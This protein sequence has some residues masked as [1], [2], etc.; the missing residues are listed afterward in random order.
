MCICIYPRS[1]KKHLNGY[2]TPD[3]AKWVESCTIGPTSVN[4][5]VRIGDVL[6]S[7]YRVEGILGAGAMGIVVVARHEHLGSLVALKFMRPDAVE[8]REARDRFNREARAVARLRG[9]H[10]ARVLDFGALDTGAPYIVMEFLEGA[11]L[12]AVL[13]E[14][15]PLPIREAL[16]YVL[17]VCKAMEEAHRAGIVH[18][19]LKPKNLFLTHRPDGTPL[20]K[21]L[22]F[23]ISKVVD[24]NE[25][26]QAMSTR[27]S[28]FLGTPIFMSPEQIRSAKYVDA[29]TDIYALGAVIYHLVT[30]GFPFHA[31]SFGELF[32][33]IFHQEPTPLRAK[34]LDAPM[35][36]EAIVARCLQKEPS[37]RFQNVAELATELRKL[38]ESPE[39]AFGRVE[40]TSR[41]GAQTRNPDAR[42][43]VPSSETLTASHDPSKEPPALPNVPPA[44]EPP[45]AHDMQNTFGEVLV[46]SL[47]FGGSRSRPAYILRAGL[48]LVATFVLVVTGAFLSHMQRQSASEP[49]P[50]DETSAAKTSSP[51][52]TST[53]QSQQIV[54]LVAPVAPVAPVASMQTATPSTDAGVATDQTSR[55]TV[56]PRVEGVSKN[57]TKS[58]AALPSSLHYERLY[59]HEQGSSPRQ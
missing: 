39:S 41:D 10:I 15:G 38:L 23:G 35:A 5:P 47:A 53:R 42:G 21:V 52:P 51:E 54:A 32:A 58:P 26:L 14:R 9:E 33:C 40:H 43:G 12:A 36:L 2:A 31:E 13:E 24:A 30:K 34:R 28:S 55:A 57:P 25:D 29:R 18:R 17:D 45:S 4:L 19:D 20:V 11:D 44:A 56:G 3:T 8:N 1:C 6:A 27:T 48:A 50:I 37:A 59:E 22:D 46:S 49:R 7:K 16:A